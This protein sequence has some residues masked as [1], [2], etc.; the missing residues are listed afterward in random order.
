MRNSMLHTILML[1][2]VCYMK[3]N[4]YALANQA[5]EESIKIY[6]KST[7]L[8]Y[9]KSQTISYNKWSTLE[10]LEKAKKDIENAIEMKKYEK[11][12]TESQPGILKIM[13]LHNHEEAYKE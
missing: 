13:N 3:L 12:F 10:E 1:L 4:H 6:D 9:R 5:I 2:G 11:I 7:Q 8:F